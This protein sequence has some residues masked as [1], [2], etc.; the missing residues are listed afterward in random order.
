VGN[1]LARTSTIGAQAPQTTEYEYDGYNKLTGITYP[2]STTEA[3]SYDDNGQLTNRT[4]STGEV[5]EY[6]WNTRGFLE[7]VT[8]PSGET[9]EYSYDGANRPYETNLYNTY[10]ISPPPFATIK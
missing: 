10:P 9:I 6:Q 4:K 2:D 3:L 7:K 1:I 5:T 8:L